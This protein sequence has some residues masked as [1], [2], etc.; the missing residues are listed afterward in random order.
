MRP[1]NF[2]RN[3][4]NFP[5]G[6]LFGFLVA[7]AIYWLV[8]A[9][10]SQH[11]ERALLS[12]AT[13]FSTFVAATLAVAGVL[14]QIDRI[15]RQENDQ[16]D[17]KLLSSRTVLPTVLSEMR[18]IAFITIHDF[19]GK[20]RSDRISFSDTQLSDNF[21]SIIRDVIESEKDRE[22]IFTL[23]EVL[24]NYQV[25]RARLR[26]VERDSH[27]ESLDVDR[28]NER[29]DKLTV[30]WIYLSAL[31]ASLFKY[32]RYEEDKPSPISTDRIIGQA[33]LLDISNYFLNQP[34]VQ[35]AICSR[36]ESHRERFSRY[37]HEQ[38]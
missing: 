24:R 25:F 35:K 30:D 12:C 36:V 15:N 13:F 32:S 11:I 6:S 8:S 2:T 28:L 34:H 17:R 38:S 27:V 22:I 21:V 33:A 1:L 7:T 14:T 20:S 23:S 29:N 37:Q 9:G 16:I 4:V 18:D 26:R 10:F 31:T 19:I 3:L 5:L